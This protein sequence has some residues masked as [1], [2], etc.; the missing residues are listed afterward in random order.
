VPEHTSQPSLETEEEQPASAVRDPQV[1]SIPVIESA[2]DSPPTD[3]SLDLNDDVYVTRDVDMANCSPT[4]SPSDPSM[5][6]SPVFE[7][8]SKIPSPYE[9]ESY[10]A[11]ELLTWKRSLEAS[12]SGV[13]ISASMVPE[14]RH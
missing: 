5:A 10:M 7:L 1:L 11:D 12:A 2:P 6:Q 14:M 9:K 4:I 3:V 13:P 8:E